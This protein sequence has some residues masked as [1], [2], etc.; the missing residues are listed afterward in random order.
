MKVE[1]ISCTKM[2]REL[3]LYTKHTRLQ[4]EGITLAQICEWPEEKKQKELDYMLKTIQSS[5]EFV[6]YV[7]SITGVSRAFTHQFVRTRTGSY[8]QESQRAV[9]KGDFE[10]IYP[11]NIKPRSKNDI[12]FAVQD[13]RR[14]YEDLVEVEST[15]VARSILP[16]NVETSIIGKFNLR[17]LSEMAKLRLCT[18]TQGEYQDVFREMRKAVIAV[19]PWAEPFIRVYCAAVGVCCFPNYKECPIKPGIFDPDVGEWEYIGGETNDRPLTKSE[20]QERWESTRFE[21]DPSQKLP[22]AKLA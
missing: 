2:A 6:D 16:T 3:L 21:A 9:D 12:L 14:V 11:E 17:T 5:W 15:Q 4:A 1:L 19:H 7:F 20:I 18:R 10:F 13:L 8:A 22:G